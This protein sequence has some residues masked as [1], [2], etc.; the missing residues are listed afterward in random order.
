MSSAL[1][2]ERGSGEELLMTSSSSLLRRIR[3]ADTLYLCYA[4]DTQ[5]PAD[6]G[7]AGLPQGQAQT[8]LPG[9]FPSGNQGRRTSLG[10]TGVG[11]EAGAG[12]GAGAGAGAGVGAASEVGKVF[13]GVEV[14]HLAAEEELEDEEGGE[15]LPF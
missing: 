4:I 15:G 14:D 2:R 11:V 6:A 8:S 1:E 9:S 7:A 3:R 10:R 12:I 13:A 5:G